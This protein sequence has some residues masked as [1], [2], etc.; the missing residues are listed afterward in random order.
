MPGYLGEQRKDFLSR[1]NGQGFL[2][3]RAGELAAGNCRD[4]GF[5]ANGPVDQRDHAPDC[6]GLEDGPQTAGPGSRS[7]LRQ[8]WQPFMAFWFCFPASRPVA[9]N[10]VSVV[11]TGSFNAIT[12]LT[13]RLRKAFELL[14]ITQVKML[15]TA[16]KENG[17]RVK[18]FTAF[19]SHC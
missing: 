10:A 16:C 7:P 13:P 9:L 2:R 6:D 8:T 18:I 14:G 12:F 17:R 1:M 3:F 19:G 5:E 15:Q 4:S 11:A